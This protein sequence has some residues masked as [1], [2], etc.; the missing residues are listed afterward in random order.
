MAA[1]S[2]IRRVGRAE[3]AGEYAEAA[4]GA[5]VDRHVG[6][7][8]GAQRQRSAGVL[9]LQAHRNALRDLHPV[10][11]RV[12]RRQQREFGAGAGADAVDHR[13]ERMVRIGVEHDLGLLADLH[14][15]ELRFLEIRLDPGV[16]VLDQAEQRRACCHVLADLEGRRLR[17]QAVGRSAHGGLREVP[18]RVVAR[19]ERRQ[20]RRVLVGRDVGIAADRGARAG[21]ALHG[22]QL[23]VLGLGEVVRGLVERRFRVDA[24][25]GQLRLPVELRL[26]IVD[27]VARHALLRH[28]LA[29]GGAQLLDAEPRCGKRRVGLRQRDAV[30]LGIDAEQHVACLDR[31]V[32]GEVRLDDAAGGIG[33]DRHLGLADIG[34][35][36]VLV[37]S[38]GDPEIAAAHGQQR[39]APTPSGSGAAAAWRRTGFA[40]CGIAIGGAATG[41]GA[42][43]APS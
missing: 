20:H 11:G 13:L 30:R 2:R 16:A 33:R 18:G 3:Q 21:N 12:L 23:L 31:L 35:L 36:G 1:Y 43:S 38:A 19:G 34:V 22:R 5:G 9:D 4:A 15:G 25:A 37:A 39:A 41:S 26:Q 27:L 29:V 42:F 32:L 8:A 24:L 40:G 17:D 10:A 7:H 6:A 28:R 14:A